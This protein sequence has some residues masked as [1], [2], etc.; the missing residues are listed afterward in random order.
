MFNSKKKHF[1]L[2]LKMYYDVHN[3]C[4]ISKHDSNFREHPIN[5][6]NGTII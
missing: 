5:V 3:M 6:T 4:I 1:V 2:T